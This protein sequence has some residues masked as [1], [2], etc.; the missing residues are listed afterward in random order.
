MLESTVSNCARYEEL[1]LSINAFYII[2]VN[3]VVLELRFEI[4][5]S[6][7]GNCEGSSLCF[8]IVV[9]TVMKQFVACGVKI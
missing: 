2:S 3:Q 4:L 7:V 5:F 6:S 1:V 9:V 8:L